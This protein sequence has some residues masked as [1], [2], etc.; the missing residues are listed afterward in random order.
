MDSFLV[1]K[2][3]VNSCECLAV[4]GSLVGHSYHPKLRK[5]QKREQEEGKN[6][7][8]VRRA[9]RRCLLHMTWLPHPSPYSTWGYLHETCI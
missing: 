1:R 8:I 7:Q 6:Q 3:R 5:L 2:L 9:V 4:D